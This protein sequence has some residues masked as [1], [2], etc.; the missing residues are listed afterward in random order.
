LRPLLQLEERWKFLFLFAP[1]HCS[2]PTLRRTGKRHHPP[3]SGVQQLNPPRPHNGKC[4][5]KSDKACIPMIQNADFYGQR[6][7]MKSM[8]ESKALGGFAS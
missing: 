4:H 7:T 3:T 1:F 2:L 6:I 5:H 8:P